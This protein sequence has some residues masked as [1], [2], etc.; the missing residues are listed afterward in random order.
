MKKLVLIG[1]FL[2]CLLTGCKT[3]VFTAEY[4]KEDVAFISLVSSDV[5][6]NKDVDVYIDEDLHF[7]MHVQKAKQST[8][9][10]NGKLH[11]IKP[12]K[13]HMKI[14]YKGNVIYEKDVFLSS[15]QTKLINL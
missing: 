8:E 3:G 13:R 2:T 14:V 15:Q 4:G 6:A 5:M 11:S 9:K 12:G 10:H 7:T 1:V